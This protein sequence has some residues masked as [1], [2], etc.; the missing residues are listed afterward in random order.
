MIKRSGLLILAL[1]CS[2][3][4]VAQTSKELKPVNSF[5]IS[6]FNELKKE[7][8]NVFFSPVSCYL[9]LGIL[10]DGASGENKMQI[11]SVL[12]LGR[13]V[14]L[15]EV[16][17]SINEM[18]GRYISDGTIQLA[19]GCWI[20]K[21]TSV[22]SQ[23]LK[24]FSRSSNSK[25]EA[26]D[27]SN[28][29]DVVKRV[30]DWT[31]KA[32]EGTIPVL[33]SESSI[34]PATKLLL[35]NS[36]Y[37]NLKWETKFKP[38]PW[39]TRTFTDANNVENELKFMYKMSYMEY[40][41][42]KRFHMV[43]RNL[44][45]GEQAVCFIVPKEGYTLD[46]VEKELTAKRLSQLSKQTYD[47]RVFLSIPKFSMEGEYDFKQPLKGM[48]LNE[49]FK[50]TADFSELTDE[51]LMIEAIRQKV[52]LNVN[53]KRIVATAVT[54]VRSGLG[55]AVGMPNPDQPVDVIAD[56]PFLFFIID[57]PT[58]GIFFMGRYAVPNESDVLSER[59]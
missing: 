19:N 14:E 34:G 22:R 58:N 57:K 12:G 51:K 56:R 26:V 29:A 43:V 24:R 18:T 9:S 36:L 46:D 54:V 4:L 59:E 15:D 39:Y 47:Q 40:A 2:T 50:P 45:Q 10:A 27:M 44:D 21:S 13:R 6:L 33:L 32:T 5:S 3:A 16:R 8:Q 7:H 20:D 25:V 23:F 31:E 38:R 42:D 1:F 48:G 53:E 37:L 35:C 49:M 28:R 41:Y 11:D 55:S 30:N 17:S 52:K